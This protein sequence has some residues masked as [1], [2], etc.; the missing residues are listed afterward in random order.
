MPVL[1]LCVWLMN[2]EKELFL[3]VSYCN[4]AGLLNL[5]RLLLTLSLTSFMSIPDGIGL[6]GGTINYFAS[7][8]NPPKVWYRL[9]FFISDYRKL[10]IT[11]FIRNC[12]CFHSVVSASCM[13]FLFKTEKPCPSYS[14]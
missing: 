9:P 13:P 11:S 4:N 3:Q 10:L 5:L 7:Y 14:N 8:D 6:L 12:N 2:S 1:G